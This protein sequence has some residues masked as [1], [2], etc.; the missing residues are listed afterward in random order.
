MRRLLFGSRSDVTPAWVAIGV[1]AAA[2]LA[3]AGAGAIG[4]TASGVSRHGRYDTMSELVANAAGALVV[5]V[6]ATGYE[7]GARASRCGASRRSA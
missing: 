6:A 1:V 5:A 7:A 3:S 2:P 4:W